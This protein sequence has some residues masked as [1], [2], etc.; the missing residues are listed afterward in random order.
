[1][2][3]AQSNDKFG[4]AS[5][6]SEEVTGTTKIKAQS[7]AHSRTNAI[8]DTLVHEYGHFVQENIGAYYPIPTIHDECQIKDLFG[9]VLNTPELAWF[10]GFPSFFSRAVR[11]YFPADYADT[12]SP[13]AGVAGYSPPACV[14]IGQ[15]NGDSQ[16]IGVDGVEKRV[17][18]ALF[19]LFNDPQGSACNPALLTSNPQAYRNCAIGFWD[20]RARLIMGIFD[21][22]LDFS[23]SGQV[24]LMRFRDAWLA[25][26][27]DAQL[28]DAAYKAVGLFAPPPPVPKDQICLAGCA[29]AQ[30]DC[31]RDAHIGPERGACVKGAQICR[32]H[33]SP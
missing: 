29:D 6:R 5:L 4:Y 13:I 9:K 1:M 15:I 12:I 19:M 30:T 8:E 32:D 26:G 31:M 24:N 10:E 21:R 14:A 16:V 25:R 3:R 11:M 22:E 20:V 23:R 33:C 28:I 2:Q 7:V 27:G 17:N 18:D